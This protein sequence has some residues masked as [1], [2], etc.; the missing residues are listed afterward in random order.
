M[1][2]NIEMTAEQALQEERINARVLDKRLIGIADGIASFAGFPITLE[3]VIEEATNREETLNDFFK[4][5]TER[6]TALTMKDLMDPAVVAT[7]PFTTP[8]MIG[9]ISV[10]SSEFR[11]LQAFDVVPYNNISADVLVYLLATKVMPR[12]IRG[13]FMDFTDMIANQDTTNVVFDLFYD[14]VRDIIENG[15]LTFKAFCLNNGLNEEDEYANYKYNEKLEEETF[16]LLNRIMTDPVN[17]N[18]LAAPNGHEEVLDVLRRVAPES[19]TEW[20]NN[21][22]PEALYSPAT[23]QYIVEN[24][25]EL[26]NDDRTALR[27]AFVKYI[28][29]NAA[30]VIPPQYNDKGEMVTPE[31][32]NYNSISLAT[33]LLHALSRASEELYNPKLTTEEFSQTTEYVLDGIASAIHMEVPVDAG[34]VGDMAPYKLLSCI[35]ARYNTVFTRNIA[36]HVRDTGMSK[37]INAIATIFNDYTLETLHNSPEEKQAREEIIKN[38]EEN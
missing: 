8:E 31:M 16:S 24:W 7:L 35:F 18:F 4:M 37:A 34:E 20:I 2:E 29:D 36:Q 11:T 1:A 9:A 25:T 28:K 21:L 19:E 30:E 33:A 23:S 26:T 38:V 10:I 22:T 13:I 5:M 32:Y 17:G 12:M 27:D 14:A 6:D 3:K 15:P